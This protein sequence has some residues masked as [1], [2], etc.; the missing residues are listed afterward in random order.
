MRTSRP[1]PVSVEMTAS[2][3]TALRPPRAPTLDS[4]L[5]LLASAGTRRRTMTLQQAWC[6]LGVHWFCFSEGYVTIYGHITH[7]LYI[8]IY[9][10]IKFTFLSCTIALKTCCCCCC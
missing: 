8:Y 3:T 6:M 2:G 1:R 5:L 10:Y 7:T 4:W 9:I